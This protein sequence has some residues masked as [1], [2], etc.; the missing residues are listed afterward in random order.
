MLLRRAYLQ[1][2]IRSCEQDIERHQKMQEIAPMLEELARQRLAE[3]RV[4]LIDCEPKTKKG[5]PA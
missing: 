4:Q 1:V 5:A 3:L 2:L